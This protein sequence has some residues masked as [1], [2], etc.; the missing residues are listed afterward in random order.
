[1]GGISDD[2]IRHRAY[3][4]WEREGRQH[5]RD[6]EHWVQAQIELAAESRS[7]GKPK[8]AAPVRSAAAKAGSAVKKPSTK[9]L[10]KTARGPAK[11]PA[12]AKRPG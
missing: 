4:I 1:M 9:A 12:K 3:L 11:R 6:Y 5:G 8:P 2:A 10:A 7:N